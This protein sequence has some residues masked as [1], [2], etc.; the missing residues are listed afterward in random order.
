MNRRNFM[1]VFGG[2][3]AA[4]ILGNRQLLASGAETTSFYVRG[5]VMLTFDD[6]NYLRIVIPEAHGHKA[7]L[8]IVPNEGD[9]RTLSIEGH[10]ALEG[11][12]PNG[13]K[14]DLR[15]PELLH[16]REIY[17]DATPKIDDSPSIISIPWSAIRSVSTNTVSDDRWTFV[18]TDTGEE[19][20]TVRPRKIAESLKI[21]LVS[22]GTLK[23]NN[24]KASVPLGGAKEL[25]TD[26]IPV[27]DDIGDFVDH[28][29]HYMPY[30]ETSEAFTVIPKRLGRPRRKAT[31]PPMGNS[32]AM[33]FP[34]PICFLFLL[35]R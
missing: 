26:F 20:N 24:G 35:A 1:T 9:Q 31:V 32:Y 29:E 10:G 8:S 28:F 16:V 21:E 19:V 23:L 4:T 18:R 30:V 22:S 7:T 25:W 34:D 13:Q 5:L 2:V 15:L 17:R 3:S 27:R 11:I 33:L 14:P 6:P 12:T